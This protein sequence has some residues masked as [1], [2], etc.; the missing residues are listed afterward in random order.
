MRCE[1]LCKSEWSFAFCIELRRGLDKK[2]SPP[3]TARNASERRN[4]GGMNQAAAKAAGSFCRHCRRDGVCRID[5]RYR[6]D[7]LPKIF[8]R[9][10]VGVAIPKLIDKA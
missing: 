10:C 5:G 6:T 3:E 9:F 7:Y 8:A 4:G 1:I 2:K